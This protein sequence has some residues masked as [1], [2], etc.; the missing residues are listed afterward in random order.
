MDYYMYK[1]TERVKSLV[2]T[3]LVMQWHLNEHNQ[4]NKV[5]I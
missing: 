5:G 4:S 3:K 1:F 2:G